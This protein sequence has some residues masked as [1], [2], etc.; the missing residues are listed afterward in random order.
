MYRITMPRLHQDFAGKKGE[1]TVTLFH[2]SFT[3]LGQVV[4][5]EIAG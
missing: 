4:Q 3:E 2:N 5:Q 1:H